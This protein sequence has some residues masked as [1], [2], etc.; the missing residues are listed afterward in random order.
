MIP[1]GKI[2]Q[3]TFFLNSKLICSTD[4]VNNPWKLE[5]FL[6]KQLSF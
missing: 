5:Y 3:Q 6:D 1:G 2:N 4:L